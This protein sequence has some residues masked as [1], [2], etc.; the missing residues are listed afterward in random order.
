M[1]KGGR[2]LTYISYVKDICCMSEILEIQ[3]LN[4]GGV[5]VLLLQDQ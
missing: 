2:C 4:M 5:Y 1:G 3:V